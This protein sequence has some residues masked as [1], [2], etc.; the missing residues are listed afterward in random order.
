MSHVGARDDRD[1]S[2]FP[3]QPVVLPAYSRLDVGAE[4]RLRGTADRGGSIMLRVRA[5][6]V[7]GTGYQE[8][9]NFPAP[10]RALSVGLRVASRR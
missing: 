5:E 10:G 6:N 7:L 3:A 9:F 2:T 8:V 4:L 1:F